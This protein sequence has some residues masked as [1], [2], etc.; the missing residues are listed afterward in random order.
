MQIDLLLAMAH[1]V[2]A[3]L[4]IALLAV[5]IAIVRPGLSVADLPRLSRVDA[6]YGLVAVALVAVGICRVVFGLKGWEYYVYY[7]VFRAKMAAFA[8]IA[9]LSVRPTLAILRW[10][11][12]S[13]GGMASV[14]EEQ[15]RSLGVYLK[16]QAALFVVVPLLADMMAR[17]VLY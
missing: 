14:P 6:L 1:H 8:V 4:L 15:I 13:R 10:R 12:A 9:V 16:A 3:F 5:E 11:K 17:G 7:P 2:L